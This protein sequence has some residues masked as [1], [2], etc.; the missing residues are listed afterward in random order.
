MELKEGK[1]YYCSWNYRKN[2]EHAIVKIISNHSLNYWNVI[3][4]QYS[5]KKFYP[6][7]SEFPLSNFVRKADLKEIN[8]L[9]SCIAANKFIP[10][11]EIK[12]ENLL[13][14]FQLF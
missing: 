3:S 14:N 10:L 1:I 2:T 9:N 7:I 5:D 6:L 12:E 8:Y 11:S 4:L 13:S